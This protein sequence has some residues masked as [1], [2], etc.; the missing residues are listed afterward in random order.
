MDD[1]VVKVVFV[2]QAVHDLLVVVLTRLPDKLY[3]A[4]LH[5]V[6]VLQDTLV[7]GTGSQTASYQQDGLLVGFESEGA[8]GILVGDGG[9]QQ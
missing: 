2:R 8:D 4:F 7:D 6:E 1:K 5:H 3:V 9:L